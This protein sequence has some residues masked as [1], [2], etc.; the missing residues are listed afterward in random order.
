MPQL[1]SLVSE[2]ASRVQ[3]VD[4]TGKC[5]HFQDQSAL[6]ISPAGTM[7]DLNS[8]CGPCA[9]MWIHVCGVLAVHICTM[10]D[11]CLCYAYVC[12]MYY[13]VHACE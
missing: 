11:V 10:S 1:P 9:C 5:V 2:V 3:E 7:G 12:S 6:L 4:R 13:V 8:V